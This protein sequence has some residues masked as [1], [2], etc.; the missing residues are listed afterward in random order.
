MYFEFTDSEVAQC[1]WKE[2]RL[3]LRFSAARLM[4]TQGGTCEGEVIWAPLVLTAEQVD[5]TADVEAAACMGRLRYG[6]VLHASQR[7][8]RLPVPCEL[9]GIVT[10]ELEFAQ[11]GVV[12]M[13]CKGLHIHPL[14][15]VVVDA[16]QC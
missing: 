15:G 7:I 1:S 9:E 2:D 13:R 10:L 5:T 14:Q 12:H 6:Y 16:F 11:G 8:Q 4:D 3:Q